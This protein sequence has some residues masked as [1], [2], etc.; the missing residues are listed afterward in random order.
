MLAVAL[1]CR[2]QQLRFCVEV[3]FAKSKCVQ[4]SRALI[5]CGARGNREVE[6]CRL[7]LAARR[8][9]GRSARAVERG[10]A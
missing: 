10:R 7:Q 3:G 2:V 1:V 8:L 5:C 4:E 9:C 6:E